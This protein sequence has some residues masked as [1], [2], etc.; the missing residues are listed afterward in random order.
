MSVSSAPRSPKGS[1]AQQGARN[2]VLLRFSV[3]YA[4][5]A[6]IAAVSTLT[7]LLVWTVMWFT[8]IRGRG[9]SMPVSVDI[10]VN[11]VCLVLIHGTYAKQYETLCAFMDGLC[12]ARIVPMVI[13]PKHQ[14]VRVPNHSGAVDV[15]DNNCLNTS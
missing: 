4:L 11:C 2:R 8:G 13:K 14:A 6:T 3:K 10:G 9:L 1:S 12:H 7:S 15:A 5:L